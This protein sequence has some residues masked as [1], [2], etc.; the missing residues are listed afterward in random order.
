MVQLML[1]TEQESI[2]S[3]ETKKGDDKAHALASWEMM[4]RPKAKG[5][6]G[7]ISLKIQNKGLL[8]KHLHNFYNNADLPWVKL[9]INA[10]YYDEVPHVVTIYG[11]FWW[12]N[13]MNFLSSIDRSQ[14]ARWI[15]EDQSFSGQI[16][17]DHSPLKPHT[18]NYF[19]YAKYKL[20]SLSNDQFQ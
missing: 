5:G 15:M 13:I 1:L 2:V 18:L 9:V 16:I 17:G 8:L 3:G 11:S 4:C 19:S 12:R 20:W 14:R 7:I 10:Y 6:L